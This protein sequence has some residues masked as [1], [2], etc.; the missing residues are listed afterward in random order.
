MQSVQSVPQHSRPYPTLPYPDSPGRQSQALP[1][2]WTPRTAAPTLPY[3]TRN[4]LEDKVGPSR[5]CGLQVDEGADPGRPPAL[6]PEAVRSLTLTTGAS[7]LLF[8]FVWIACLSTDSPGHRTLEGSHARPSAHYSSSHVLKLCWA[9][10][11]HLFSHTWHLGTQGGVGKPAGPNSSGR[12]VSGTLPPRHR[13]GHT[14][15][16]G[17]TSKRAKLF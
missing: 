16:G 6:R 3:P 1:G 13:P 14:G 15:R 8:V 9:V 5:A 12:P 11:Q 2:L 7:R 4:H 17:R 10:C